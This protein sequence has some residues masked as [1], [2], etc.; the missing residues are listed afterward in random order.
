MELP[1][2][3][4]TFYF[5]F[6]GESGFRYEGNVTIKC[7]LNVSER[8]A[9]ELNRSRLLGDCVNPTDS[10]RGI[11]VCLST[12]QAKIIE[13]PNWWMQ[14]NGSKLEDED[15]LVALFSRIEDES[16]AWRQ[17]LVDQASKSNPDLG[18]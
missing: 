9:L 4:R 16:D 2:R 14:S 10:L 15:A 13:A 11:A 17:E 6:T 18:K 8:H 7:R 1:K 5:D 12:C 3:E